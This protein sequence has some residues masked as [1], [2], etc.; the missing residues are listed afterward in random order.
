MEVLDMLVKNCNTIQNEKTNKCHCYG[1][2]KIWMR[3]NK[4]PRHSVYCVWKQCQVTDEQ[5]LRTCHLSNN[6]EFP[7]GDSLFKFLTLVDCLV[8]PQTKNCAFTN[9]GAVSGTSKS[10]VVRNK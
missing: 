3:L 7:S 9:H 4:K 8:P 2:P 6:E 1:H 5:L 10:L